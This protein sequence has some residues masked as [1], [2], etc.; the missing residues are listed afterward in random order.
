[1]LV[2]IDAGHLVPEESET[3]PGGEADIA[4][5]DDANLHVTLLHRRPDPLAGSCLPPVS[6]VQSGQRIHGA[7]NASR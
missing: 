2:K 7:E 3:H 5:T 4:G 1:M 6:L